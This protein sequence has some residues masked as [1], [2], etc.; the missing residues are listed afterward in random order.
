MSYLLAL[1]FH[2]PAANRLK[3]VKSVELFLFLSREKGVLRSSQASMEIAF[4]TYIKPDLHFDFLFFQKNEFYLLK[5]LIF[6]CVY[7]YWVHKKLYLKTMP[8]PQGHSD[9]FFTEK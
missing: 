8:I 9:L 7:M 3:V 1:D 2:Q 5:N 6:S 4:I